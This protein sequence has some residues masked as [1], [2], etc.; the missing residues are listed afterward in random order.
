MSREPKPISAL[1]AD[2]SAFKLVQQVLIRENTCA[3]RSAQGAKGHTFDREI[4]LHEKTKARNSRRE[5]CGVVVISSGKARQC[6]WWTPHDLWDLRMSLVRT[7]VLIVSDLGGSLL[8]WD[9][10]A[11][12]FFLKRTGNRGHSLAH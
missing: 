11:P 8:F 9:Q 4:P 10:V 12:P 1:T 5:R 2:K 3:G 6:R 7:P